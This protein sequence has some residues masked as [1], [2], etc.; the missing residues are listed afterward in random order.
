MKTMIPCHCARPLLILISW[1]C[2]SPPAFAE[3]DPPAPPSGEPSPAAATE[4]RWRVDPRKNLTS[5][6]W[7]QGIRRPPEVE[8]CFHDL[9]KGNFVGKVSGLLVV[10]I[11]DPDANATAKEPVAVQHVIPLEKT[12]AEL[13]IT[14][15]EHEIYDVSYK[16]YSA[17]TPQGKLAY[18][19]YADANSLDLTFGEDR[20][21]I[22]MIDGACFYDINHLHYDFVRNA[23]NEYLVLTVENPIRL[24]GAE[25]NPRH[26]VLKP[27]SVLVFTFKKPKPAK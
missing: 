25:G 23:E 13:K 15:D 2:L 18:T 24:D 26:A 19:T 3:A 22:S 1:L 7:A 20:Y 17:S 5:K 14:P 4:R 6:E 21:G 12:A 27:G 8:S 10:E 11:S 16:H 9:P